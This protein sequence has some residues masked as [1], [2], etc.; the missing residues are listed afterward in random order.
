MKLFVLLIGMVL[1]LEGMPYVAAP[2]AMREWLAKLS[3]MP[4]SQLR[5]F[6]LFAMMLGLVICVIAQKTS[7]LD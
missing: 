3:R 6:G 5:A 4:A 1:V 7:I 2:E